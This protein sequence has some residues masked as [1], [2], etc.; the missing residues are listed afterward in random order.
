M[1]RSASSATS[2]RSFKRS[3]SGILR[4]YLLHEGSGD[5]DKGNRSVQAGAAESR[6]AG[7]L[8]ILIA[9][10]HRERK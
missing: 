9:A 10:F 3:A 7:H 2:I 8:T 6:A 5:G 4:R 1:P